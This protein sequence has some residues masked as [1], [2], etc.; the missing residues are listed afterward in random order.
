MLQY[1]RCI[2]NFYGELKV[3]S[4]NGNSYMYN[5]YANPRNIDLRRE[6]IYKAKIYVAGS[7]IATAVRRP[8][9][10]RTF[11]TLADDAAFAAF[12]LP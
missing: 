11:R 6:Q 12:R 7:V 10:R 2:S 1:S 9:L 8:V 5:P 3:A 4:V